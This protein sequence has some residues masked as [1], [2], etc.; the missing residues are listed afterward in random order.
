MDTESDR[1]TA[2][3][4]LREL[5]QALPPLPAPNAPNEETRVEKLDPC[6]SRD[7]RRQ[8]PIGQAERHRASGGRSDHQYCRDARPAE[9]FPGQRAKRKK[10]RFEQ[11]VCTG[12]R[13]IQEVLDELPEHILKRMRQAQKNTAALEGLVGEKNREEQIIEDNA[14]Y[15]EGVHDGEEEEPNAPEDRTEAQSKGESIPEFV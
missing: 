13:R 7:H 12:I 5:Q 4:Q 14:E 9:R 15:A 3:H 11:E 8:N 10:T 1:R 6:T 2:E